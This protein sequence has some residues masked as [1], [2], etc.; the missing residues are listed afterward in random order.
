MRSKAFWVHGFKYAAPFLKTGV[1]RLL[2]CFW[3][4][5]F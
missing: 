5:L 2:E 1:V 4:D 3:I